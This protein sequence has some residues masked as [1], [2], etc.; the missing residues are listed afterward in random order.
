M[1][2]QNER[3]Q[4]KLSTSEKKGKRKME[5]C[6]LEGYDEIICDYEKNGASIISNRVTI[7][8]INCHLSLV[9]KALFRKHLIVNAKK[10]KNK[11]KLI[12]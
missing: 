11:V 10:T 4:N 1:S 12:V 2:E 5:Y 9:G 6:D 8:E 3:F 7:P